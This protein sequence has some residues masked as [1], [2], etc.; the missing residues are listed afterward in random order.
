LKKNQIITLSQDIQLGILELIL[1]EGEIYILKLLC[2]TDENAL[3]NWE[4]L[5]ETTDDY[6]L[7]PFSCKELM[8]SAIQKIQLLDPSGCWRKFV[9]DKTNFLLGLPRYTWTKNQYIINQYKKLGI[10]LESENIEFIALKGIC[11]ILANSSLALMRTSRDIDILIKQAD[12]GKCEKIFFNLGWIRLK[13]ELEFELLNNPLN[14]NAK[15]FSNKEGIMSLDVHFS[16]ISGSQK[17]YSKNFTKKLWE[18]KVN[19]ESHPNLFIPSIEDRLII[20][21]INAYSL[22][23]WQREHVCKYLYDAA[24]ISDNIT[25]TQ[26]ESTLIH[27]ENYLG[28]GSKINQ[29]YSVVNQLKGGDE[30]LIDTT[31]VKIKHRFV[32]LNFKMSTSF[33]SKIIYF[34][35]YVELGEL[36]F[37]GEKFFKTIYFLTNRINNLIFK[38]IPKIIFNLFFKSKLK[39]GGSEKSNPKLVWHLI[40]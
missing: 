35:Y 24:M 3:K 36:L 9:P 39:N 31:Y 10:I 15:T 40:K 27:G 17:N 38:K 29:L 28:L 23:N 7:L 18:R 32:S 11:E 5:W 37:S 4:K 25:F 30:N 8:P 2:S 16:P 26:L 14:P 1:K 13:E 34:R 12:W 6:E 33:I 19:P 20:S 22:A 21:T